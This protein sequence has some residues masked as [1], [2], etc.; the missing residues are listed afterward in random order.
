[1]SDAGLLPPPDADPTSDAT[2]PGH[3]LLP[4]TADC[5]IEAWGPDRASC[6][7]EALCGLVESFAEA[8]DAAA[9]RVLPLH[10]APGGP[11]DALVSLLE[12]VIYAL[13]VFAV[14]PLRFHLTETEGG[15][16]AGDM[17]V[18]EAKDVD[19]VGPVPKAV[20]Y[21]GLSMRPATGGWRCHVLVDV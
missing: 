15:G 9:T 13:D 10:G 16:V 3:R 18:V 5:I 17:E 7:S 14:V 20:S 6:V 4:H 21:H 11:E 12:D 2:T 1:M 19:L 8:R